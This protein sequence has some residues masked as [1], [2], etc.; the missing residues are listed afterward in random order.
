[1][2]RSRKN[3]KRCHWLIIGCCLAAAVYYGV[4]TLPLIRSERALDERLLGAFD[5]LGAA[6]YGMST[7]EVTRNIEL[8]QADIDAF[9]EIGHEHAGTVKFSSEVE[10]MLHRPFQLIDFDH[11]KF[12]MMNGIRQLS[13][14]K[15][16]KV[17]KNWEQ[18]FP[19]PGS[20][21]P[22][23][24]W[25]QLAVIDQLLRIA[26]EAGVDSIDAA[27]LL[28]RRKD[29]LSATDG[30]EL[31]VSLRMRLTGQMEAIHSVIMMLPLNG[32]ELA[33]LEMSSVTE[34]KSS[35]FLSRFILT[36]SSA[37]NPDEVTFEFV[38]SGFL[39]AV[40]SS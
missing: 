25:A 21:P 10:E 23:E 16:V 40:P 36:K 34:P 20:Q 26:I 18:N 5:R 1:M 13:R 8:L 6:G 7:G 35:F 11:R 32:E 17:F 14:E 30:R 31:E 27:E 12:L 15:E 22:Y 9:S 39:D 37:K 24:L 29:S 28:P 33:A 19:S 3:S 2:M 38:A 4:V